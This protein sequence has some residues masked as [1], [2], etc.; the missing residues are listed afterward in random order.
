MKKLLI[1]AAI[2]VLALSILGCQQPVE[3]VTPTPQEKSTPAGTPEPRKLDLFSTSESCFCHNNLA[4]RNG[5]DVSILREWGQSMMAHASRNPYWRAKVSSELA[6]FPELEDVIEEKCARCHMPMASVQAKSNGI[7]INIGAF[8]NQSNGMYSL[9]IE[10]VSCTLCHQI[11]PDNLGDEESFSGGFLI[12]LTTEK[13]DRAI[14]GP[15]VPVRAQAMKNSAG[16]TP[17]QG[18]HISKS[19]LCAVCHTLYTPYLDNDGNVAGEFPEQTPYL[20]WLNSQYSPDKPCQACHMPQAGNVKIST[21]PP[22][23]P[24]RAPFFRHSFAG[25]N[26]QILG[27]MGAHDGA[28]KS[29]ELLKSG[30]SVKIVSAERDGESLRVDV[31]V[32]NNAGHKF[33]TGFPSRR[34]WIHLVVTD[35]DGNMVFESGRLEG[36]RIAGEDE[37]YE[38]HHTIITKED[39]VQIY[40]AVMVDVNGEVTQTL[41]RAADYVK[42]NRILP[43]GFDMTRASRDIAVRGFALKDSDFTGGEDTVSYIISVSGHTGPFKV[44]VELLYQPVSSHFLE[45]LEKT[46]TPEINEF[47]SAFSEVNPATLVSSDSTTVQ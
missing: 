24:E 19:E 20:E 16:Y 21:M 2:S 22:N 29:E 42:D 41:L 40:E 43:K 15:F 12:D 32:E 7:Q 3:K 10:G 36:F 26:V 8:L 18:D 45:D 6:K 14:F 39:E 25:G 38:P 5:K 35:G 9:A 13:P 4:D 1:F 28:A 46:S 47:L 17:K 11:L 37:P 34:A 27:I 33:P 44:R 31:K 23:L 30:A